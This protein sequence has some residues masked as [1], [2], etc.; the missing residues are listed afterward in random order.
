M[1][2]EQRQRDFTVRQKFKELKSAD[3]KIR[4]IGPPD[5]KIIIDADTEEILFPPNRV[6]PTTHNTHSVF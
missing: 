5:D 3:K 6:V 2:K 4:L 1:T